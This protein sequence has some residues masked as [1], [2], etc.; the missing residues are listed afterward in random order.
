[1][2]YDDLI[3]PRFPN[4]RM[5]TRSVTHK[6]NRLLDRITVT[7]QMAMHVQTQITIYKD[8]LTYAGSDHI[9]IVAHFPIDT[10]RVASKRKLYGTC[11]NTQSGNG[12]REHREKRKKQ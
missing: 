1:M 8:S 6:T 4:T 7:R 3:R 11:M 12:Q 2:K 9:I 10:T 5:V